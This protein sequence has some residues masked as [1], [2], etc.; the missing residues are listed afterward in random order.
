MASNSMDYLSDDDKEEEI[1]EL[2]FEEE[3][4]EEEMD[5][6]TRNI[7][8]GAKV[9]EID[10]DDFSTP[11]E[12]KVK[13]EKPKKEQSISIEEL[14]KQ[15]EPKKWKSKRIESKKPT[16]EKKEKIIKR[17]F[18]PRLPPYK[19]IDKSKLHENENQNSKMNIKDEFS[20]PILK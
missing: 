1:K 13:K 14:I 11:K 12:K 18:N 3:Y 9:T 8:F 19:S 5:E 17:H 2:T 6:E 4:P 10:F 20:F 7:I 16:D 15:N